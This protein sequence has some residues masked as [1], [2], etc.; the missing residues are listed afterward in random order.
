[1]T[2]RQWQEVESIVRKEQ[3][4]TLQHMDT[5]RYDELSKILGELY[6]FAH[7]PAEYYSASE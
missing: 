7:P 4:K 5:T 2:N 6:H 3:V 1:M